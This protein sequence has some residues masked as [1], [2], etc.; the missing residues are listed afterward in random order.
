MLREAAKRRGK[1]KSA[2]KELEQQYKILYAKIGRDFV[3]REEFNFVLSKIQDNIDLDEALTL[4]IDKAILYKDL[5]DDDIIGDFQ[6][7]IDL[8][9]DS[10][11]N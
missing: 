9:E 6:D 10:Y 8:S 2:S 1:N 5:Y 4:A 3:T 11:E 7:L